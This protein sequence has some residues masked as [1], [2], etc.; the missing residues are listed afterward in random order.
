[1]F[2]V[3]PVDNPAAFLNFEAKFE[4]RNDAAF[5]G[6][7]AQCGFVGAV[8][9]AFRA[10]SSAETRQSAVSSVSNLLAAFGSSIPFSTTAD[11]HAMTLH[12]G[13]NTADPFVL[14][15]SFQPPL[16]LAAFVRQCS[17]RLELAQPL[18]DLLK[19]DPNRC[20]AAFVRL[21][22]QA[23]LSFKKSLMYSLLKLGPAF[24]P[25]LIF[26]LLEH[27]KLE[28]EFGSLLEVLRTAQTP[29]GLDYTAALA[30]QQGSVVLNSRNLVNP[31]QEQANHALAQE[32]Q[33]VTEEY[34]REYEKVRPK[35][36]RSSFYLQK[37]FQA[38]LRKDLHDTLVALIAGMGLH[39]QSTLQLIKCL[40]EN[41]S[42]LS[43]VCI[44]G[45]SGLRLDFQTQGLVTADLL[46]A[47]AVA[48]NGEL[49]IA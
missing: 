3:D 21:K 35:W 23:D 44:Y 42:H 48:E 17:L 5:T 41:F 13:L 2:A 34:L 16:D 45:N 39:A 4:P 8:R 37:G 25:S 19:D 30:R 43:G 26:A 49:R 14:A 46:P 9:C 6:A 22:L 20:I 27:T 31:Q 38:G 12:F 1:M 18:S 36:A 47:V 10:G 33:R 24:A 29:E 7:F 15:Q 40:K 32:V 11:D 28:F